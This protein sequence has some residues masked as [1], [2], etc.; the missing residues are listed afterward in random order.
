MTKVRPSKQDLIQAIEQCESFREIGRKFKI[1][2]QT[3]KRW[4]EELSINYQSILDKNNA[5]KYV[6]KEYSLL[7]IESILFVGEKTNR[8]REAKCKCKCGNSIQSRLDHIIGGR[9]VSCGCASKNRLSM[10]GSKNPAFKG[11]GEICANLIGE[12]KRSAKRRKLDYKVSKEYLWNLF[13]HQNRKC[14]FTGITLQFGRLSQ[15]SERTASLDRI[16]NNKGYIE[17][18][19]RWV[20]KD[21]NM[22]KRNKEDE[23]IIYLCNLVAK[24]NP[25]NLDREL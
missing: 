10:I 3:V 9:R 18:N 8:R 20:Y 2:H 17:N 6:N 4:C 23:Y 11:Y 7:K 14:P 12:I 5:I 22:L 1:S 15:S 25:R 13:L 21:I 19:L 16:D 24:E